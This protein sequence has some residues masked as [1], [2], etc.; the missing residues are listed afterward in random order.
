MYLTCLGI[1]C[2]GGIGLRIDHIPDHGLSL[3]LTYTYYL[4]C[5]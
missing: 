3:A 5:P 2:D 4:H 1:G